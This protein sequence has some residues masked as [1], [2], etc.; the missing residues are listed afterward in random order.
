MWDPWQDHR[1][2]PSAEACFS[3]FKQKFIATELFPINK[4]ICRT[5][6]DSSNRVDLAIKQLLRKHGWP[7]DEFKW[8]D[9]I[10]A[11]RAEIEDFSRIASYE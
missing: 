10:N 11:A 5:L 7:S 3:Y 4:T 2:F 9:F 8:N 6:G 1:T